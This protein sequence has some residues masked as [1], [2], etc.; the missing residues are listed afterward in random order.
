MAQLVLWSLYT[1]NA[2]P[3]QQAASSKQQA[4]SWKQEAEPKT[5]LT[6]VSTGL[7]STHPP[8]AFAAAGRGFAEQ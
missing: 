1:H 4:G 2:S 7:L 5:K 6:P 3:V 8:V